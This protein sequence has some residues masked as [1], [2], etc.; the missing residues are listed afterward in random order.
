M[1]REKCLKFH[2]KA[3]KMLILKSALKRGDIITWH[4]GSNVSFLLLSSSSS[5]CE[6][7]PPV[8]RASTLFSESVLTAARCVCVCVKGLHC[9]LNRTH[10][11]YLI[12]TNLYIAFSL[13]CIQF[14]SCCSLCDAQSEVFDTPYLSF[15]QRHFYDFVWES[16]IYSPVRQE[17]TSF[18]HKAISRTAFNKLLFLFQ[19]I[20]VKMAAQKS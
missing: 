4:I 18:V 5:G 16:F 19:P 3:L 7:S 10:S 11:S 8:G 15:N 13:H 14:F 17:P 20:T 9:S 6:R 1:R 12:S 2:I